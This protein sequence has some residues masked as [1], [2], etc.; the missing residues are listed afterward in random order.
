MGVEINKSSNVRLSAAQEF[1]LAKSNT[2]LYPGQVLKTVV[3]AVMSQN[4]VLIDL[5]GQTLTARTPYPFSPGDLLEVKVLST[6]DEPILEILNQISSRALLQ[7]ALLEALPRQAPASYLLSTLNQLTNLSPIPEFIYQHIKTLLN[8]IAPMSELAKSLKQVINRS[9]VFLEAGLLAS[10]PERPNPQISDDF[11]AQCQRLLASIEAQFKNN[12]LT[13]STQAS[14]LLGKDPLP[15]PGAI[16]QPLNQA[17]L[18]QLMD[19]SSEELLSLLHDQVTQVLARTTVHQVNHLTHNPTQGYMLMLDLPIRTPEGLD[20]IPLMIKQHPAEPMH[21]S[22]WSVSFAVHLT[23]LGKIQ[24]TVAL[25]AQMVDIK[26][27]TQNSLTL[28]TLKEYEAE[29]AQVLRDHGLK[30]RDCKLQLGLEH[31]PIEVENLHLLDIRI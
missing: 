21:P 26:L 16:P 29:L 4:E 3:V 6:Q 11:K 19:F 15:L 7:S 18:F 28:D 8:S 22:Q 17:A 20:V 31:N 5:D 13:A 2:E 23:Q 27:N 25:D 10:D 24:G 14:K 30:L 1:K 9:G 12:P